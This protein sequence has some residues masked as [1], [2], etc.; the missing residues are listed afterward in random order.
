M[1]LY[2]QAVFGDNSTHFPSESRCHALQV[3]P[4]EVTWVVICGAA[5]GG[6]CPTAA[7]ARRLHAPPPPNRGHRGG[8][9]AGD[10]AGVNHAAHG[11][12]RAVSVAPDC[13]GRG[14]Y[15]A[16]STTPSRTLSLSTSLSLPSAFLAHWSHLASFRSR[17]SPSLQPPAAPRRFPVPFS[18]PPIPSLPHSPPVPVAAMVDVTVTARPPPA[19]GG[20]VGGGGPA[21]PAASGWRTAKATPSAAA[22][23]PGR[24][25]GGGEEVVSTA[26]EALANV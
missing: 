5:G 20:G 23:D 17:S 11:Q 9:A 8:V 14:A 18:P 21:L 3:H 22:A 25:G 26:L 24:P 4:D 15:L 1:L 12:A 2:I 16:G 13:R 6:V 10:A 7:V 19:A